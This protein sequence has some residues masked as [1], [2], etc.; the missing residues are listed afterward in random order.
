MIVPL[1]PT[2]EGLAERRFFSFARQ[3]LDRQVDGDQERITAL[4]EAETGC[5]PEVRELKGQCDEYTACVRV[6]GDLARLR[7]KLVESG[8]GLELHSPRPQDARNAAPREVRRR[9]EA[10]RNE[11]RPRVLQQFADRHVRQFIRRLERPG[12]SSGHQSVKTLIADGAELQQRL[13]AGRR[14]RLDDPR[15][16]EALRDA[17]R[18]Y[19]Q[20]VDAGMRDEHTGLVLRDIWRYFRFTW[21]IPQTSIPG[22][23]L[24]YLVRDAAHACHAVIGIAALSNCAVQL[25]PRDRAIGWSSSGLTAALS[26]LFSATE[27]RQARKTEDPVLRMQGI[28]QWLRPGFAAGADPSTETKRAALVRVFDWL[29]QGMSTALGEIEPQGL[30]TAEDL[31]APTQEVIDR[32]RHLSREFASRRQEALA[33]NGNDGDGT[34]GLDAATAAPV[35]DDVLNLEAKHAS[36]APIH[37]SRRM[38][39]RKKRTFELARLLDAG[40]VLAANREAL[41]D[42]ATAFN[43]MERDE[44]RAAINTAMSAIKGRRIGTNLLEITTC[45]AIAPYNRVLGGKLVALLLLSPQVAADNNR[46]Y[47]NEPAIIRSQVKN[48]RVVPDNTLVWLGT[49]SLFSH[50]SS[51]Y[52]RLRLPAG[53]IAPEQE[54]IRYRYLGETSGY[55]TVQF[56]DETVRSLDAVMRRRRGYRDVNSVFGEGASPRMRKLRSGL[57]AIGFNANVTMV[58][59]QGRRIYG[60][61]LFPGAGAYLCGLGPDVPDY[62]RSPKSWLMRASVSPSSGGTAGCRDVSNTKTVGRRS[63]RPG[64]G[65]SARPSRTGVQPRRPGFPVTAT[66]ATT[67]TARMTSIARMMK[68]SSTSGA[69]SPGA[70]RTPSRR[71]CPRRVSRGCT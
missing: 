19:L 16:N 3:V 59:H 39:V 18:P 22:R 43:A 48:S 23:S 56:A 24:L 50:G 5:A 54:E 62:I 31:A 36:N 12:V 30:A 29:H 44:I 51:Q 52:E 41:T 69:H 71:G 20:L 17:V 25:A 2:L 4:V 70:A 21:S 8:H 7:W 42:P 13:L 53:V 49:T 35:D 40:R 61:P 63:A 45:G 1:E 14:F 10:I 66:M 64:H 68:R 32:L 9:K 11:L 65:C 33:G 37:N 34:A 6:L 46:R 26:T 38:L 58:H 28:Y 55:G 57:D 67:A 47:G 15:R 27:Q 60:V